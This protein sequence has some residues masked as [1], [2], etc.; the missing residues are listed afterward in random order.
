MDDFPVILENP[1][2]QSLSLFI[3][4]SNFMRPLRELSLLVDYQLFGFNAPGYHIQ[5]IFWHALNAVLLFHLII[6]IGLRQRTAWIASLLFIA[7]PVHVEVVANISHR[8]DSLA[9]A[10]GMLSLLAY[11]QSFRNKKWFW[12]TI[13]ISCA[14]LGVCRAYGIGLNIAIA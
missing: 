8:K 4:K 9:L 11:N 7:H 3:N 12:L 2:I 5:Q 1:A 10:F 13:T 6:Q 14:V